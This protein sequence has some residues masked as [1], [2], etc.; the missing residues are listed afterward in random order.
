MF[1]E[2]MRQQGFY[3]EELLQMMC[4]NPERLMGWN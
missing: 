3:D 4:K 2:A 1:A